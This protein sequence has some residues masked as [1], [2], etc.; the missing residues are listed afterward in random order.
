MSKSLTKFLKAGHQ[1]MHLII[2]LEGFLK[3]FMKACSGKICKEISS[4][5]FYS[6]ESQN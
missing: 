1:E 3:I 4:H 6:K 2:F 5:F